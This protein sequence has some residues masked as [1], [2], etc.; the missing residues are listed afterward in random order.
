MQD[1]ITRFCYFV[2][3][4]KLWM[5]ITQKHISIRDEISRDASK[6]LMFLIA[7]IVANK[8]LLNVF[9]VQYNNKIKPMVNT[10]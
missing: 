3:Y 9:C 6:I 8:V 4:M 10:N 5:L 7:D 1:F 2:C